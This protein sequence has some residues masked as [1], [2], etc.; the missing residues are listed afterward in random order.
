MHLYVSVAGDNS[1]SRRF[2]RSNQRSVDVKSIFCSSDRLRG[3]WCTRP[4]IQSESETIKGC[5]FF[6]SRRG[7]EWILKK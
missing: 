2:S 3:K 5:G 1:R 4:I 6:F 7:V